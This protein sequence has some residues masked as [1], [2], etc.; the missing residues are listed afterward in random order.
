MA[1]EALNYLDKTYRITKAVYTTPVDDTHH[2]VAVPINENCVSTMSR[3][4]LASNLPLISIVVS[5]GRQA[6]SYS[7]SILG[8]RNNFN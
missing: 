5:R 1:L 4:D 7:T 3:H 6:V 2:H 8:R